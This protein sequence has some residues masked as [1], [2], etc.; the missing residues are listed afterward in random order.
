MS[1]Y[2]YHILK[3]KEIKLPV[4]IQESKD[5]KELARAHELFR[6]LRQR[7]YAILFNLHHLHF[8]AKQRNEKVPTVQVK[9]TYYCPQKK[10][11]VSD[12]VQAIEV[13]WGVP[14]VERLWLG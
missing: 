3:H 5:S 2:I 4:I 10:G 7:V 12:L 1:P 8:L 9:E 14:T 11:I 6:P 13:G